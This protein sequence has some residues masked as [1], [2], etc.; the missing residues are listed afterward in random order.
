MKTQKTKTLDMF[1]RAEAVERMAK[2]LQNEA[3]RS[4]KPNGPFDITDEMVNDLFNSFNNLRPKII[5]IKG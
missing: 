5:K 2:R 3:T 4:N 1:K